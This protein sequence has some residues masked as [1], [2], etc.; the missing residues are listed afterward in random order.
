M[1]GLI[2]AHFLGTSLKACFVV[3]ARASAPC[4]C[5]LFSPLSADSADTCVS[6]TFEGRT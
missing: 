5:S 2:E 4:M 6:R 3:T 1:D